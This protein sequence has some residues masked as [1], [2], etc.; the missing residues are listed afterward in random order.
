MNAGR[1]RDGYVLITGGAGFVGANL[2]DRLA[3]DGWPV[4]I[5]DNLLRA[6]VAEN[7]QWLNQRHGDRVQVQVA[8]VRD[9]V[10]VTRAVAGA[11]RVF[12]FAGQVAVTT[13]LGDP[14]TDFEINARGTLNVLEGLRACAE[15]PPLIFTSTNKVYGKLG[16]LALVESGARY[17]PEDS[18]TRAHGISEAQPLELYSPYGCSKG[19]ADQYVLD[20]ARIYDLPTLVFRMS[21]IYG[22]RQFGTEDQGWVA[23]FLISALKGEPITIYGDGKQVR[24]ILFVDDLVDAFV[25]AS[26]HIE[27][28][29]GRAFN[30]GGGPRNAVSLL[31]TLDQ[32]ERQAGRPLSLEFASARPGDQL[33]YVSDTAAF[34]T[35][36]GWSSSVG[37]D[38]GLHRLTQWLQ[39]RLSIGGVSAVNEPASLASGAR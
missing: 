14:V 33:Y 13:S 20:Y 19:A 1:A 9:A 7:L 17:E 23:H 5:Y 24:D 2:A 10:A 15:P 3:G 37:P 28:L 32:I 36:T 30:I 31:E 25:R 27:T 21:C 12:H 26:S 11:S 39:Q 22:P 29:R 8:D 34:E 4:L 35:A 38:V 6:H 16:A 18:H